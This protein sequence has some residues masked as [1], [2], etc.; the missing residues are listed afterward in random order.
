M[1]LRTHGG[2]MYL[3]TV[4]LLHTHTLTK[5]HFKRMQQKCHAILRLQ[6]VLYACIDINRRQIAFEK[7]N[8]LKDIRSLTRCTELK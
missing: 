8:G 3:L 5:R 2:K 4:S 7:T 1:Q 6:R